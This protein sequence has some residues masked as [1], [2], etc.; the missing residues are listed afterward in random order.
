[1]T[2]CFCDAENQDLS[3]W[4]LCACQT[5]LHTPTQSAKVTQN[6][7]KSVL[8]A[9]KLLKQI[10]YFFSK[11]ILSLHG[12]FFFIMLVPFNANAAI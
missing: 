6:P 8:D 3:L 9:K 1:M 2:Q 5:L 4:Y 11:A 7:A 10:P 12:F